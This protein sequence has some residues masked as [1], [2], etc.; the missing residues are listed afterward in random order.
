MT[1][2]P[3]S[4]RVSVVIATYNRSQLLVEAI[5]SVLN[6]TFHDFEIIVVDDGSTDDTAQRI[7]SLTGPIRYFR[8]DHSG[9]PAVVRNHAISA[10]EGDVIAFLDDDDL[11]YSDKLHRQMELLD[12]FE[13]VG[14][15]Y[16]DIR[17]ID[18]HGSISEPIL[19]PRQK[20]ANLVFDH[21]LSD[22]FIYPST[23]AVRRHFLDTVGAFDERLAVVEDYDLWLRLA[24]AAQAGCV[25][26]PLALIRRTPA[27]ISQQHEALCYHNA[28]LAL[29]RALAAYPLSFD[30]RRRGRMTLSKFHTHLGL[31]LLQRGELPSARRHFV[32]S[33]GLNPFQRRAWVALVRPSAVRHT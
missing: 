28:T 18:P 30:Q 7:A 11:W 31:L 16:T 21:L 3:S 6:Q 4:P 2:R 23:V 13:I 9:R 10:A 33:L 32:Q 14:F 1:S 24:H 8:L 20:E 27:G 17:F 15:V 29:E 5:D 25:P 26:E 19:L 12:E 22:C